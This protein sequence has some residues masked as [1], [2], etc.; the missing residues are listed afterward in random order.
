MTLLS[1]LRSY[2]KQL[3]LAQSLATILRSGDDMDSRPVRI[4]KAALA[5]RES[6]VAVADEV[7]EFHLEPG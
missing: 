2:Q 6:G 1:K 7:I 3:H 4:V 5:L